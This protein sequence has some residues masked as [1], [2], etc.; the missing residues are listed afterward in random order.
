MQ[1]ILG[2]PFSFQF[3]RDLLKSK[4][5][6][7]ELEVGQGLPIEDYFTIIGS[8][9][10]YHTVPFVAS[11]HQYCSQRSHEETLKLAH[12]IANIYAEGLLGLDTMNDGLIIFD[13]KKNQLMTEGLPL[14]SRL[15]ME[16]FWSIGRTMSERILKYWFKK[17][18]GHLEANYRLKDERKKDEEFKGILLSS[19]EYLYLLCNTVCKSEFVDPGLTRSGSSSTSRRSTTAATPGSAHTG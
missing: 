5:E 2:L 1:T 18:A 11:S 9:A 3:I 7:G 10:F 19:H 4:V 14:N 8:R 12:A 17:F 16:S 6:S 13:V 15:L